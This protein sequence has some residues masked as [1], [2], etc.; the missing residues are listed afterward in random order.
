MRLAPHSSVPRTT[1][2][3]RVRSAGLVAAASLLLSPALASAALE[4][5]GQT[6]APSAP[7]VS[8]SAPAPTTVLPAVS[9]S[10][11][12]TK[13]ATGQ[14]LLGL[15]GD[16]AELAAVVRRAG[17]TFNAT[18]GFAVVPQAAA[19][20]LA[21]RFGTQV[22]W[23][24]P[25]VVATRLSSFDEANNVQSPWARSVANAPSLTPAPGSLATI[26][27]VD[28]AVDH[29]VAELQS[30]DVVNG[31]GAVEPHGTMVAST[32]AAPY[33]G[34]G[35]VGV[36]PGASV[37][38][39]GTTL[40]CPDVSNGIVT[41]VKRGAKIVNLSLGFSQDCYALWEAVSYAYAKHVAVVVA[42]GNDGDRGNPPSYPASYPHVI[43]A[44]AID[45]TL[46]P[47]A[48][49]NYNDYVDIAAPGVDVPVDE[50]LR[51]DVDDG[52]QDGVSTVSGTSFSSPYVAG[53]L[54]WIL[55][56]RPELDPG[57]AA[58]V[59]R[60]SAQDLAT[61]GF[62]QHTGFGLVQVTAALNAPAPTA[63]TLE[64]ND[65]PSFT[66]AKGKGLFGK[67]T[68][69]SGGKRVRL[70]ALG[71]SA[72]DPVDAYRISVPAGARVKISLKASAGL[73]NLFAFDGTVSTFAGR[74]V[75]HSTRK[76]T[77]TDSITLRNSGNAKRTAFV[78]VNSVDAGART[79]SRYALSIKRG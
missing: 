78:V 51:F 60:E 16:R 4:P 59:L 52:A 34:K 5:V 2:H 19:A 10:A 32:A 66:K 29:S 31:V 26:G 44:A 9:G 22:R 15:S 42:A 35:V 40:S 33:D 24:G 28:D 75:A 14:W 20:A 18:L 58:G 7:R 68:V 48:F 13:T 17:G 69:W 39:W 53:A 73:T 25:D 63:D 65:D 54:S 6:V 49:S 77:A 64:P 8:T 62:D 79:L 55:G 67:P 30:A 70:T 71:D 11:A 1:R 50:P 47:A 37:L 56:A 72:D 21:K 74:P 27:I 57:Q 3:A 12:R 45:S 61:P 41:L 36:A 38:S 23:A 76:G 43:T 46:T